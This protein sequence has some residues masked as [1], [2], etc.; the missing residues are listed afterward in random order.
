MRR[1][2]RVEGS[3]IGTEQ[4]FLGAPRREQ[5]YLLV[6]GACALALPFLAQEAATTPHGPPPWLTVAVLVLMS[7]LN[8]EISRAL[9]GGLERVQQPHK[10]L[11][12]WAFACAMLLDPPWLLVVVPITYVHA[13][14]RGLRVPLWKWIGSATFLVL[15]GLASALVAHVALGDRSTWMTANGGRGAATL[16]IAAAVFLVVETALFSGSA[17]LNHAEDEVWLRRTLT[18]RAFYLTESGVLLIGALLAAVWTSGAWF[19]LLLVPVYALVQRAVLLEPL[20]ERAALA[21]QLAETNRQLEDVSQF[22]TDLMGMLAH[23]IG[24]PLTSVRGYAELGAATLAGDNLD[25]GRNA[26]EVI[27]RN[28]LQ[29]Q[30]V[31]NEIVGLVGSNTGALTASPECC[32]VAPHLRAAAGAQPPAGQPTVRCPED[33]TAH[34]QPGHLDQVLANLLSNAR[35]YAG[36]ATCLEAR[37]LD[38]DRVLIA[39]SDVG[40][41]I[42][43]DFRDQLFQRS[44]RHRDTAATVAGTGIGLFISRALAR[45]NGGDLTYRSNDPTGSRF[46]LTLP[47]R[48]QD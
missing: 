42:P 22:K 10:A 41:G 25:Q 18:S 6:A 47:R 27:K 17:L 45:A 2:E 5:I 13:R 36:G 29:I 37:A 26:F 35:K 19:V 44:A 30:D 14:W 16:V 48:P 7:A 31:V 40:P 33:L 12:A 38:S 15:A 21:A 24:N 1:R 32:P 23:E 20:R 39:V 9:T 4:G 3:A 28:A 34:V 43:E 46:E 8:V 11:S